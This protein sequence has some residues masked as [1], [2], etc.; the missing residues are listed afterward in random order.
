MVQ[1]DT[2]IENC[3]YKTCSVEEY[4]QLKY[5][6]SFDGNVLYLAIFSVYLIAQLWLGIKHRTL[7]YFLGMFCGLFLEIW[8][9]VARVQLYYDVFDQLL[10]TNYLIGTTIAPAF[11]SASIYLCLARIIPVYGKDLA[12]L[13][14][15]TITVIFVGCDFVSLV[16]QAVGGA[17]TAT[18]NTDNALQ[19]GID[20]MIA[21]LAS[22][23]VSMAAF[24]SLCMHFAWNVRRNPSQRDQ[25]S[26]EFSRSRKFKIFLYC[27]FALPSAS[28]TLL[29]IV[30]QSAQPRSRSSSVAASE[31]QN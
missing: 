8:G 19:V 20:I 25:K 3:T 15:R 13:S 16:L 4:G 5:I 10:F 29:T 22:Q 18:A 11:F 9:Y 24:V 26:L 6:P 14:A 1:N 7:G 23:V 21:G 12:L 27:E 17:M 28:F 30:Q 31:S 2:F